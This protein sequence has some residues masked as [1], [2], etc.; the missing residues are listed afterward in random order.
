MAV[1]FG[2]IL[3]L[4]THILKAR[5]CHGALPRDGGFTLME[6]LIV[7]FIIGVVAAVAILNVGGG[8]AG[9]RTQI[10]A[11]GLVQ[12]SKYARNMALAN[13]TEVELVVGSNG[14]LRVRAA[15]NSV[16]F[17]NRGGQEEG[18]LFG[19]AAMASAR[20]MADAGSASSF[21]MGEGEGSSARQTSTE[22]LE[23]SIALEKQFKDVDFIF[24]GHTDGA[25]RLLTERETGK[26]K[27][28]SVG[29][30]E[31]VVRFTSNGVG[32][33]SL[34]KVTA[35]R[36][37]TLYVRLDMTGKGHVGVEP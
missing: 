27:A 20:A 6:L 31:T 7:L 19:N 13:Q 24:E 2:K 30:N 26:G 17:S 22:S 34:F 15:A 32:K 9:T 33:P 18:D 14:T 25:G 36:G 16:N 8:L 35:S 10:A 3:K 23:S 11:R 37:N 4:T 28:A 29:G 21:M 12:M 1:V 5:K